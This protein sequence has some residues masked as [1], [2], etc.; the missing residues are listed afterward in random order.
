MTPG[1]GSSQTAP[2]P[3]AHDEGMGGN[4][5]A[6]GMMVGRTRLF[7][8]TRSPLI[9]GITQP[10]RAPWKTAAIWVLAMVLLAAA[11]L[12]VTSFVYHWP[13]PL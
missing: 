3:G 5:A 1:G 6:G 4:L 10:A 7:Q 9:H 12:A 8:E 2:S 13:L 11:V